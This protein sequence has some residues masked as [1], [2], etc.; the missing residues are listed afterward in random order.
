MAQPANRKSRLGTSFDLFPLEQQNATAAQTSQIRLWN[1][2]TALVDR[3]AGLAARRRTTPKFGKKPEITGEVPE[4]KHGDG[5]ARSQSVVRNT[6]SSDRR[7][8]RC[9]A[10]GGLTLAR[11]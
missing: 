2:V 7:A 10:A 9:I 8:A 3:D 6:K 1:F 11:G 4:E 5:R